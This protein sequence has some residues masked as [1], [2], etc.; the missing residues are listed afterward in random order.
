MAE[1]IL[2]GKILGSIRTTIK[3][4]AMC[5]QRSSASAVISK[6]MPVLF[7]VKPISIRLAAGVYEANPGQARTP[8]TMPPD[9][10]LP[11]LQEG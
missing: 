3:R 9:P 11:V 8:V 10:G 2:V 7:I 1:I 6:S 5:N 4:R